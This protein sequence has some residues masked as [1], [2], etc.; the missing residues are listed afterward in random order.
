MTKKKAAPSLSMFDTVAASN[1]GKRVELL[2]LSRELSGVFISILGTDSDESVKYRRQQRDYMNRKIMLA[3]KRGQELS[4]D[5]AEVSEEK[6]IDLLV[7]MTTGWENMPKFEED[8]VGLLEFSKENAALL[9][10]RFPSIK[11]Q[12][13]EE[14]GDMQDFTTG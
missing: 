5:S 8:G 11:R 12:L 7:R 2:T 14:A 3:R 9:Y 13:D 4:L 1:K 10:A 6:E